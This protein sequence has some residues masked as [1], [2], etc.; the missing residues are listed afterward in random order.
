MPTFKKGSEEGTSKNF[1]EARK[2]LLQSIDPETKAIKDLQGLA[3]AFDFA[4]QYVNDNWDLLPAKTKVE[5]TK[6]SKAVLDILPNYDGCL[7]ISKVSPAIYEAF[8]RRLR[9]NLKRLLLSFRTV[10]KNKSLSLILLKS[11]HKFASSVQK[12]NE[13][14]LL[15][16]VFFTVDAGT[17]AKFQALLDEP[18]PPTDKLR[19]LLKKKAPWEKSDHVLV[20]TPEPLE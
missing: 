11:I 14:A 15:D 9:H 5:L 2:I 4:D 20:K 12:L 3:R 17:F 6:G 19:R 16:Q 7:D 18:L 1:L 13:D 8:K 10:S